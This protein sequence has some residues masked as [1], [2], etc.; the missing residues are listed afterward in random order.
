MNLT[1]A[2]SFL[3]NEQGRYVSCS[4]L[5][6]KDFVH[7]KKELNFSYFVHAAYWSNL[8]D[9]KS[10]EFT[11]LCK[12]AEIALNIESQGIVIHVGA[13]RAKLDKH[14]QAKYVAE[15]INKLFDQIPD[16]EILLENSPHSGRNFGGDIT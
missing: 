1:I 16:I 8:T 14:D 11:S 2:Q 4:S 7:A 15:G 3:I 10:K 12:E 9:V 13:T 5:A 6:I